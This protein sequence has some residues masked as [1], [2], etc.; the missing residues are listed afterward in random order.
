MDFIAKPF[1]DEI[2]I[3]RVGRILELSRLQKN[4]QQEV[5]V[6][7]QRAEEKRRQ[8]EQLSEEVMQTLANT[9]DAKDPYTNGFQALYPLFQDCLQT[10]NGATMQ[11]VREGV[12]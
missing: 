3:Q 9:I 8:V 11:S 1:V 5:N 12:Y 4:L 2:M 7:T 10:R 6:Q